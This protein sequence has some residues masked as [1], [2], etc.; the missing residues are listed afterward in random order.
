MECRLGSLTF[1][2]SHSDPFAAIRLLLRD[3]AVIALCGLDLGLLLFPLTWPGTRR[4]DFVF[5]SSVAPSPSDPLGIYP[6]A[7][8]GSSGTNP[9]LNPKSGAD[10]SLAASLSPSAPSSSYS[11]G[12]ELGTSPHSSSAKSPDRLPSVLACV[13]RASAP[14]AEPETYPIRRGS[15]PTPPINTE[16]GYASVSVVGRS[17][18]PHSPSP[19]PS[20]CL[21]L[22]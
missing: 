7:V 20:A 21:V 1:L 22:L 15:P 18:D 2:A 17:S 8:S 4:A 6:S 3:P 5:S 9:R 14:P 13:A 16:A 12:I 19:S 11:S 10:T